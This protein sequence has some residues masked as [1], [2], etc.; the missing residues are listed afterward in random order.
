[1]GVTAQHGD[2]NFIYNGK[3]LHSCSNSSRYMM[4]SFTVCNTFCTSPW[5]KRSLGQRL[6]IDFY[7]VLAEWIL[8]LLDVCFKGVQ[9]YL[10][11]KS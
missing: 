5:Y 3:C 11:T 1:M 6:L 7:F 4:N 9:K 10:P 8:S 2:D